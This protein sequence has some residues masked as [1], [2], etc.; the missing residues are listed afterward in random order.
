M[1]SPPQSDGGS[2]GNGSQRNVRAEAM[3]QINRIAAALK[4]SGTAPWEWDVAVNQFWLSDAAAALF[5]E[6]TP[7]VAGAEP[8]LSDV[9]ALVHPDD[10]AVFESKFAEAARY[11]ASVDFEFRLA[12]SQD[13]TR[14]L[15]IRGQATD[16]D[17]ESEPARLAGVIFDITERKRIEQT[18]ARLASI[19]ASSDD[20]IIATSLDGRIF[21][22]NAGAQRLYGY[23]ESQMHGQSITRIMS[24]ENNGELKRIRKWLD[25]GVRVPPFETHRR[26]QDDHDVAVFVWIMPIL[27]K[28]G[29]PVGAS[30]IERD[31]TEQ[32]SLEQQVYESRQFREMAASMEVMFWLKDCR[33]NR[34]LYLSPS[35]EKLWGRPRQQMYENPDAWLESVDPEDRAAVEQTI[36]HQVVNGPIEVKYRIVRPNGEKRTLRAR[37]L[38]ILDQSGQMYRV[39][40]FVEDITER[41]QIEERLREREQELVRLG[42]LGLLGELAAGIAHELNQPLAAIT[43]YAHG[44]IERASREGEDA[45]PKAYRQAF[46]HI[47]EQSVR[48]GRVIHHMRE[49]ARAGESDKFFVSI[50][51]VVNDLLE[52]VR[53]DL[54]TNQV[55][56]DLK[57][58]GDLPKLLIGRVEIEQVLLNLVSNAIQAMSKNQSAPRRLMIQTRQPDRDHVQ[59][60]VHDTGPALSQE[61]VA[62]I[63]HPFYSTKKEGMGMGLNICETL[64]Q[65]HQGELWAERNPDRGLSMHIRLPLDAEGT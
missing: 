52:L 28:D 45:L 65:H 59:I 4:A 60:T 34:I 10:R 23:D 15:L 38:P 54:L 42:R 55:E 7:P 50:N 32:R 13:P 29:R 53:S 56:L 5:P 46:E 58:A 63:F 12:R 44:S 20:A 11:H 2:N 6:G 49:L 18:Y 41:D 57:L 36:N 27:D 21:A 14:W 37:A 33:A 8:S 25:A 16:E 1:A 22:W 43:S 24:D 19:V 39:T 64:V 35:Y 48:A 62:Q 61:Q 47:V 30:F 9:L 40:G 31:I 3:S 51:D 26:C 17:V